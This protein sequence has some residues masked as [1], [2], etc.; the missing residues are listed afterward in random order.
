MIK[1]QENGIVYESDL[2]ILY[3]FIKYYC[4]KPEF[5]TLLLD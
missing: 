4:M 1:M 5:G 2:N 3:V